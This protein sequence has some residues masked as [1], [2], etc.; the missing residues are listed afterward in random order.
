MRLFSLLA[1]LIAL[2]TPALACGGFFCNREQ[3]VD[4]SGEQIVFAIDEAA[5]KVE[6]HVQIAYQGAAEDFAWVLPAPTLPELFLSTQRLFSAIDRVT[7]PRFQLDWVEEG[8]CEKDFLIRA[9]GDTAC[10]NC[11]YDAVDESG[12]LDSGGG[13]TVVASQRVGPYETLTLQAT[14]ADELLTWLA[15]RDFDLPADLSPAL[16]PYLAD[17]GY[18]VA[19]RLAKDASVGNLAPFGMR[20]PGS[21]PVIPIQLTRIAATP[22][23]RLQPYIFST[24]RAVP[25]NYLHVVVNDVAIDWLN[26]GGNYRQV[27]TAAA[28]EAG[29]QAFATDFAGSTSDLRDLLARPGQFNATIDQLRAA[30]SLSEFMSTLGNQGFSGDDELLNVLTSCLTLSPSTQASGTRP[31]DIFNCP[32]CYGADDYTFD[33][34]GCADAIDERIVQPLLNADSLFDRFGWLTALTSSISPAEMTVDPQF[35]I[36]PM[37]AAVPNVRTA[38]L[39]FECNTPGIVA[40][41][42]TRRLVF[43]DGT[44]VPLPSARWMEENNRSYLDWAGEAGSV[45]ALRVEDTSADQPPVT[46]SN[47]AAQIGAALAA[48]TEQVEVPVGGGGGKVAGCGCDGGAGSAGAGIGLFGLLLARRRR[49]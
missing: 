36:N 29:G 47:N 27:V 22:D 25:D 24:G 31:Q 4:Q 32:D 11:D 44:W 15:A 35:V 45:A 30:A 26:G 21:V 10:W 7:T 13:V 17:G 42:A 3:P 6:V 34:A 2:P 18:L 49:R 23:M 37:M 8:E 46:L 48:L 41:D 20:Y 28:N 16:E 43:T 19:L 33:I 9:A 1:A 40:R 38:D 12:V 39:V 5:G 14:S